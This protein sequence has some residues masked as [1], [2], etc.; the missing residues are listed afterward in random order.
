MIAVRLFLPGFLLVL[1]MAP[2]LGEAPLQ[3]ERNGT[4][5]GPLPLFPPDNWWNLDI[6]SAP[7]DPASAAFIAFI[8]NGP[9]PRKLHPDFG[10]YESPGSQSIYGF[11]FVVVGG[12][13]PKRAVSFYYAGESDGVDHATGQGFPFYPIPDEAITEP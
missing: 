3:A 8:N 5:P 6:R 1:A 2:A 13:Q 11:P 10:G 7:V 12:N 9:A 4:L